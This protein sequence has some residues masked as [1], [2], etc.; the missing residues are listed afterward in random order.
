MKKIIYIF[1]CCVIAF[2]FYGCTKEQN[3][4]NTLITQPQVKSEKPIQGVWIY[5]NE[6][7]MISENGGTEASFRKK[8][9][10]IYDNCKSAGANTVFVHVRAFS[11]SFYPSKLFP[12]TKYLT[13]EQG[14]SVNYD[15]LKIMIEE[16]HK[17]ALSFHAWLNPFR[18][19]L[20]GDTSMLSDNNPA[21]NLLN[22][23]SD[24]VCKIEEG[25][26][27]NPAS[28][29][30]HKLIIDGV[31]EIVENYNVDGIHIDDYFYPSTSEKIDK[32]EYEKYLSQGGKEKL[33]EWR[34]QKINAFVSGMYSAVKAIKPEVIVSI[35]PA[36][37]F[38]NNYNKLYA[39]VKKWCSEEG[40]C[41]WII[42]QIYFSFENKTLP[43]ESTADE[44]KTA[45]TNDKIKIVAGL[46][47]YK[48]VNNPKDGWADKTVIPRQKE[49]V[50]NLGYDG[51]C[52][53]S[54]SSLV[55]LSS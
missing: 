9:C 50:N 28:E 48:T 47:A 8:I 44:W 53:F 54:Y 15:P 42:P 55:E 29:E 1:L 38:D 13:G 4:N 22:K 10:E 33:D 21:L 2:S 11:D 17:K 41:D 30:S 39:D 6:L 5:Y 46:A 40:Y 26:Y 19:L 12:W 31:R 32:K 36:G 37:N 3:N 20:S 18:V 24:T 51:W 52:L 35:S 14:K 25:I 43:F 7:S 45:V 49:C 16:A 23:K 34:R 27:F